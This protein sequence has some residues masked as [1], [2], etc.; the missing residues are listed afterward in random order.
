MGGAGGGD[1]DIGG[2][3]SSFPSTIWSD[4]LAAGNPS[5]PA[6][7]SLM[8]QL[9]RRYWRPIYA[10]VRAA[11]RKP[12]E[13]AKD[14]TQAFFA[15]LLEN[16]FFERADRDRGSFRGYIKRALRNFVI[17]AERHSAV[18]R[19]ATP[20]LSLDIAMESA[21]LAS[22]APD[23]SPEAAYDRAWF[24]CLLDGAV[25]GLW[26]FLSLEGKTKHFEAFSMY[27]LRDLAPAAQVPDEPP[28]YR[29][30][31]EKVGMTE[32]E[33]RHALEYCRAHLRRILS[34]RIR[35][36]TATD[37]DVELELKQVL[38]G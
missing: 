4:I 22:P 17:D 28:T 37:R 9:I 15:H 33:V 19:P 11:F 34:E 38:G 23:E 32:A 2:P 16:E 26:K 12:T 8:D 7:R 14:L 1:T 30:V 29:D 5:G 25:D 31:A 35:D 3:A 27:C 36:Y 21:D 13:D 18:R 10:Y 24:R 20:I 6:S